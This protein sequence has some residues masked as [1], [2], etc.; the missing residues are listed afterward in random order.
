LVKVTS[1]IA[2]KK[3][4]KYYYYN[5]N[6]N[7]ATKAGWKLNSKGSYTYYVKN[8]TGV[9]TARIYK[10]SYQK[11]NNNKGTWKTFRKLTKTPTKYNGRYFAVISN[12][13]VSG[14][15]KTTLVSKVTTKKVNGKSITIKKATQ[16]GNSVTIYTGDK[17]D[18][19][20]TVASD[21]T[22]TIKDG[23]K[24][25]KV[26]T[27]TAY[28]IGGE[29][30][31]VDEDGKVVSEKN[32]SK[33]LHVAPLESTDDD[34]TYYLFDKTGNVQTLKI[35]TAFTANVETYAKL[36]SIGS[37]N[38]ETVQLY[39]A[40][41]ETILIF[42]ET[43]KQI[44]AEELEAN[45]AI[46]TMRLLS[47]GKYYYYGADLKKD[48]TKGWKVSTQG[49][50]TWYVGGNGYITY[51][52]L[53]GYLQQFSNGKWVS[54]ETKSGSKNVGGKTVKTKKSEKEPDTTEATT[55]QSTVSTEVD[56]NCKHSWDDGWNSYSILHKAV[57]ETEEYTIDAVYN[58]VKTDGYCCNSCT[59]SGL[60]DDDA[61]FETTTELHAH[62]DATNHGGYHAYEKV[63]SYELVTPERKETREVVVSGK[64]AWVEE[65]AYYKCT[66][67]NA[68]KEK[69]VYVDP[70][71]D[72][73][74]SSGTVVQ[75]YYYS[76]AGVLREKTIYDGG[77]KSVVDW[78]DPDAFIASYTTSTVYDER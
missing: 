33:K 72:A 75:S 62:W 39:N 5:S 13:V 42:D 25:T 31:L 51:R 37:A 69:R 57:T 3:N 78:S 68:T 70:D 48:T 66:K 9:V 35:L 20:T 22:V 24:T 54:V 71:T 56:S 6:G 8:K 26:Q 38:T 28:S 47:N 77:Y 29:I 58:P 17:D 65:H 1:G 59:R 50:D 46:C 52:I 76:S 53:K 45:V 49:E 44:D 10:K 18:R 64:D 61:W 23:G 4:G 41:D 55:E 67:C 21:G 11:W 30:K 74:Y 34:T 27:N 43:G 60:S 19:T 14:K 12:K 7:I 15:N 40:S 73:R 32:P 36:Q 16:N 2:Q 63:T